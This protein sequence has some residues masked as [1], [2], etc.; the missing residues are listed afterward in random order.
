[1]RDHRININLK[2]ITTSQLE[3]V[4]GLAENLISRDRKKERAPYYK[5]KLNHLGIKEPD[6]T[7]VNIGGGGFDNAYY[8]VTDLVWIDGNQK[9]IAT[10]H[11]NSKGEMVD[12]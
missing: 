6:F 4:V 7:E 1:M 2:K 10:T 3:K 5:L 12:N 9:P 11:Y 8:W